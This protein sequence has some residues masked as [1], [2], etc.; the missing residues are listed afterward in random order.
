MWWTV[1]TQ[2]IKGTIKKKKLFGLVEVVYECAL[3]SLELILKKILN[4]VAYKKKRTTV[5]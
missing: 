2:V 4:Y 1:H 3:I 5:H